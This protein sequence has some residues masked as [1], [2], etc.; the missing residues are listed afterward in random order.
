M[1]FNNVINELRKK[2]PGSVRQEFDVVFVNKDSENKSCVAITEDE[3]SFLVACQTYM[4]MIIGILDKFENGEQPITEE[5]Q[6]F[7]ELVG[8]RIDV[9]SELRSIEHAISVMRM[10]V[11]LK[12]KKK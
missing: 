5:E 4:P 2:M 8:K 3:A 12:Q 1:S 7:G 11:F 9:E 6:K 10:N